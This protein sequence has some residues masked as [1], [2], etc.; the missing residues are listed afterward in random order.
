MP[1]ARA[2]RKR[3]IQ[4]T[5]KPFRGSAKKRRRVAPGVRDFKPDP[6]GSS[7][8]ALAPGRFENRVKM[9]LRRRATRF[10]RNRGSGQVL[11]LPHR[12]TASEPETS[13]SNIFRRFLPWFGIRT[14]QGAC[15]PACVVTRARRP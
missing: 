11:V 13:G 9:I 7:R 1:D 8:R 4:I 5:P 2:S 10:H 14:R 15:L 3:Q 6:C 12:V